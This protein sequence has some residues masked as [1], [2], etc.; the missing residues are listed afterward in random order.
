METQL[1]R[2]RLAGALAVG[3]LLLALQWTSL[4]RAAASATDAGAQLGEQTRNEVL[5]E[6]A[7]QLELQYAIP[8]TARQLAQ[9]VRA[10]RKS[11]AYKRIA[12]APE[13]ARLLTID[14]YAIAHDKHLRVTFS[15][16]PVPQRPDGPP[17]AEELEQV[18]K[19]NG[20]IPKLEIL[21]GNVGYMRVNGVPTLA[22]ARDSVV[23]A[24]AF[25]HRT[26]ALIIDN[27]GNG[28]GDPN[29]VALYMS[30][31]SEGEPYVVNTF[32]WRKDDRVEEFRTIDLGELSYGASKPVFALTSPGT[33]SGGEEL[34][35]D[36]KVFKRGV[37]VGEVTGGGAN[38]G[39]P[40]P[41]GHQFV[42]NMPGGQPVNPITGTNWEGVGVT[43]DVAVPAALALSK[44]HS[45]AIERLT[46]ET[47][48][49]ERRSMLEAVAM[50]LDTIAE[51]D[52][53]SATPLANAQVVGA[54]APRDG[55]GGDVT[56]FEKDGRLMQHIDGFRDAAL[57]HV[58][59]NRYAREGFPDG[60]ITSF[61][62]RDDRTY[63]LLEA[64]IGPPAIREKR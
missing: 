51:A 23:A 64:P 14:L 32:H 27:R 61:L 57:V 1:N 56:I 52:S 43:P 36:L 59:G 49:P 5:D 12:S 8:D 44:A 60:F 47:S 18:R 30:Y 40:V 33:F 58:K 15:F 50:K 7:R 26:D 46:A 16:S 10:K 41:L 31:L 39:G 13:L 20:M 4:A 34:A 35:Y 17:S 42:V 48:D 38:P 11:N 28:G 2:T 6:L 22:A 24:F 25:L 63:L 45:L 53:A 55:L 21:D 9:A 3:A 54:Y 29:T 19:L 37:V 62:A